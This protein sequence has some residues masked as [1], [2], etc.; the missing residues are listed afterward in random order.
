MRPTTISRV[1]AVYSS[2]YIRPGYLRSISRY[3]SSKH[4][5]SSN[6][7]PTAASG[8]HEGQFARTSPN[9]RFDY[10][11]QSAKVE[12]TP[13]RGHGGKHF[14]PTLASFSLEGKTAVVTGGARGLGL[15]M[16]QGLMTS[17]ADIALVDLNGMYARGSQEIQD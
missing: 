12:S 8:S 1:R 15:V 11:P 17:G 2:P 13:V 3:Y 6:A 4:D 9:V 7:D 14:K 16:A 10:P 5:S